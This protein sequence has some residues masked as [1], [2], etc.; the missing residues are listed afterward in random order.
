M[1]NYFEKKGP[2]SIL[3]NFTFFLRIFSCEI[4]DFMDFRMLNLILKLNE[5]ISN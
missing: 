2:L 3:S 1:G 4:A 5:L